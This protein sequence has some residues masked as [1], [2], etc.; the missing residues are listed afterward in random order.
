MIK[1]I[2]SIEDACKA[3][4]AEAYRLWLQYEVRTDDITIIICKLSIQGSMHQSTIHPNHPPPTSIPGLAGTASNHMERPV[5]QYKSRAKNRAQL[6]LDLSKVVTP[7]D[8]AY[9]LVKNGKVKTIDEVL[10]MK[11]V[12]QHNMMLHHLSMM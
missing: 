10:R 6:T 11:K 8:L 5:R 12:V 1:V 3:V 7:E 4:V 2:P 9:D